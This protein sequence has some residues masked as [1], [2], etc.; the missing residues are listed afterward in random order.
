MAKKNSKRKTLII[1]LADVHYYLR[2]DGIYQGYYDYSDVNGDKKRIS[3]YGKTKEI[4]RDKFETD[5]QVFNSNEPKSAP[6]SIEK[7]STFVFH[8]LNDV[9]RLTV[10]ASSFEK[11]ISTYNNYIQPYLK[12]CLL[13]EITHAQL[14]QII[15]AAQ[16]NGLSNGTIGKIKCFFT[17]VFSF[18]LQEEYLEK[19]PALNL[20]IPKKTKDK[21][22]FEVTNHRIFSSDDIAKMKYT[23]ELKDENGMPKYKYGYIFLFMLNTGLRK[24]E[25][26]ALTWKDI[27]FEKNVV[28][29]YKTVVY[30]DKKGYEEPNICLSEK[31]QIKHLNKVNFYVQNEPKTESSIRVVYLLP[32]AVEFLKKYKRYFA[33]EEDMFILPGKKQN[34]NSPLSAS[35]FGNAFSQFKEAAGVQ[36]KGTLHALRRTYATNLYNNNVNLKSISEI[37]GH[38]STK[39]T[40]DIYVQIIDSESYDNN[41]INVQSIE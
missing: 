41:F 3:K 2:K 38:S 11:L 23:A 10:R 35:Y 27:D 33:K 16:S 20:Y 19:N 8:W 40:E 28:Y 5:F 7:F 4:V 13:S 17:A 32:A 34:S 39:V 21:N 31:G 29:I 15:N 14:Q 36:S 30:G 37:M 22:F 24:G 18:A 12:E 1:D 25:M 26:L 9:K 6:K